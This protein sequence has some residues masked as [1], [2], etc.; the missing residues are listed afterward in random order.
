MQCRWRSEGELSYVGC[1]CVR[2][3]VQIALPLAVVE[4]QELASQ[5]AGSSAQLSAAMSPSQSLPLELPQATPRRGM[6][7]NE[8]VGQL[9]DA[10]LEAIM[11][12]ASSS[13]N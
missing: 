12:R 13:M 10:T 3:G 5:P 2:G 9:P 7:S 1:R 6:T 8:T 11:Q 4:E